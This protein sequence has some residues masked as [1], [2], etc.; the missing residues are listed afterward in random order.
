MKILIIED[1]PK[2]ADVLKDIILQ[3]QPKTEI[4]SIIDSIQK[5]VE[6]L[7]VI[8]NSP[9]LIFMDIQLADGLS[10]EIFSRVKV[11]CPVIFC[12]AYDQYAL[13]AFKTNGIEYILKPIKEDDV[14]GAFVKFENLK[15]SIKPESE[16]LDVLR[17][18]LSNKKDFKTTILVRH[19]ESYIPIV[20]SSI[21]LFYLDTEI[22]YAYTFNNQKYAVFKSINDIENDID[23]SLFYRINRQMLINRTSITEIQPYFN[24]KVIIKTHLK[25]NEQLIVSRLKVTDFMNWMEKP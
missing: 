7:S 12:T 25:I 6:F 4:I 10:F 14:K 21:A 13:Q 9:D 17:N 3:V 22:V 8:S 18:V 5:S 15:L 20:I 23:P 2:T 11:K 24:R 1:E 16:I 19:K